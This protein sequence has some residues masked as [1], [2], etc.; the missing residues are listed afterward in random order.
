MC[1][2]FPCGNGLGDPPPKKAAGW[3][4]SWWRVTK[5]WIT[6]QSQS[7]WKKAIGECTT[8]AAVETPA[9]KLEGTG[10]WQVGKLRPD[11]F[12][13][14][15]LLWMADLNKWSCPGSLETRRSRVVPNVGLNYLHCWSLILLDFPQ[16]WTMIGMSKPNK[17][18]SPNY[19]LSLFVS[20]Y[21]INKRWTTIHC[22]YK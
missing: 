20:V 17:L 2:S 15:G 19:F 13:K 22:K 10:L 14:L 4:G 16:W 6:W 3:K 5:A 7:P 21:P 11:S 18:S 8:S 12:Y 1:K 9:Q